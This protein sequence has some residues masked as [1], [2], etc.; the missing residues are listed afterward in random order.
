MR[1]ILLLALFIL[2]ALANTTTACA[3]LLRDKNNTGATVR[4]FKDIDAISHFKKMEQAGANDEN[5]IT[6]LLACKATQ[7]SKIHVFSAG[8]ET[9]FVRVVEGSAKGCE[10]TVPLD[11][12][13]RE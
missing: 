2:S 4:V 10:G 3:E 6:P 8:F 7:G 12:V 1:T 5:L 11:F 9:A 13:Q